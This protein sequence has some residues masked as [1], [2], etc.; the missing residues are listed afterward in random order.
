MDGVVLLVGLVFLGAFVGLFAVSAAIALICKG[1]WRI[2]FSWSAVLTISTGIAVL[3][4][5]GFMLWFGKWA[6][7][8]N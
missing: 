2:E 6:S 5:L 7:G 8:F 4:V 1:V 3:V